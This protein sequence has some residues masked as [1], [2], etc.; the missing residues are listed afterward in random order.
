MKDTGD[1]QPNYR[2]DDRE[3]NGIAG[4]G[5][6]VVPSRSKRSDKIAQFQFSH[7]H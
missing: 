2:V 4:I 5:P 6:E 1:Q 3:H 7:L